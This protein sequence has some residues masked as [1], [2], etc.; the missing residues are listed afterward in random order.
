M[1]IF[2]RIIMVLLLIFLIV[3]SIVFI[4]NI[5][6]NLFEWST[7]ADRI[8]NFI[9]N[10]NPFI[11][12]LVLFLIVVISVVLLFFEFYRRK[13]KTASIAADQSGKSMITLRT[14]STQIRENLEGVEDISDPKVKVIPRQDGIIIDIYSKLSKGVNVA[15]KMKEIREI[16][17]EFASKNL[18]FKVIKANYTAV[19]FISKKVEKPIEEKEMPKEI[20]EKTIEEDY[21]EKEEKKD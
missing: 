18:G 17:S 20:P 16:A 1:N 6:A 13:I 10:A 7:V 4:V 5:F 19:D 15:E 2:N 11:T 3:F 9:T 8:L 21:Y 14:I 12:V